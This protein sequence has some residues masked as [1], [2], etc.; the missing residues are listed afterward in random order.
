MCIYIAIATVNIVS[1]TTTHTFDLDCTCM[2]AVGSDKCAGGL[3]VTLRH[4]AWVR[5]GKK[6]LD[7]KFFQVFY[8]GR[9]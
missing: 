3:G 8:L 7:T 6:M 2:G 1:T 9:A 5:I 4:M